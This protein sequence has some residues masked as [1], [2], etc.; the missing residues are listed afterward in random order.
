MLFFFYMLSDHLRVE[1]IIRRELHMCLRT[2]RLSSL[3]T[4]IAS[5]IYY[6]YCCISHP[7]SL[8]YC[9]ISHPSS[10][11]LHLSSIFT[12]VASLIHRHYCCISHPSSRHY[13]FIS[14]PSS[15]LLHLPSIFS[16]LASLIHRHY[17]RILSLIHISVPTELK[18][19]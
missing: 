5:L 3:L 16:T 10:L 6:H 12:T 8:H 17:C 18:Q 14:H 13:C 7:S 11:L 2:R 9:C 15:L 1:P 19:S 4:T